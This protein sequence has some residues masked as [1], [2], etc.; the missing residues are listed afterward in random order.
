MQAK[1]LAKTSDR[2]QPT[3]AATPV[4]MIDV[5]HRITH[6]L[7]T[8]LTLQ[9]TRLFSLLASFL[10]QLRDAPSPALNLRFVITLRRTIDARS[11]Q[12]D[13]GSARDVVPTRTPP[14]SGAV[15]CPVSSR[16]VASGSR[17]SLKWKT[18]RFRA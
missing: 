15:C 11:R 9:T 10:L 1:T 8:C 14:T 6:K 13:D 18:L 5:L 12:R 16:T 7:A 2:H 3:F 17:V 4:A